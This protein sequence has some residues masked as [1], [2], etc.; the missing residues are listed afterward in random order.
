MNNSS[1]FS[2]IPTGYR[3]GENGGWAI[4]STTCIW[5]GSPHPFYSYTSIRI[6]SSNENW[7]KLDYQPLYNG[8]NVRLVRDY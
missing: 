7:L 4:D 2:A 6:T 8:Y 1:G 3:S 5:C